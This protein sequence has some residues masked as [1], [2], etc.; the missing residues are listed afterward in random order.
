MDEELYY[1]IRKRIVQKLFRK[2]CFGKG[3][4]LIIRLQKGFP[5]HFIPYSKKAL[6]DLIKSDIVSVKKTKHGQAA[7]L[8]MQNINIINKIVYEES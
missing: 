3:H 5:K 8:N 1:E 6:K 7:C 2:G 4:I